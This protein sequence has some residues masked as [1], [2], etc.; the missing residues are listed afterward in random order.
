ME[1]DDDKA[2]EQFYLFLK[3]HGKRYYVSWPF[4]ED[5]ANL[6]DIYWLCYLILK[7]INKRLKEKGKLLLNYD[8]V[9]KDLEN[10][11]IIEEVPKKE[12]TLLVHYLP[13]Y[14][15]VTPSKKTTKIRILYDASPQGRKEFKSLNGC[16]YRGLVSLPKKDKETVIADN[17]DVDKKRFFLYFLRN[18]S[19]V[20]EN[21]P[22]KI[23]LSRTHKV[24]V[25]NLDFLQCESIKG[26]E[27]SDSTC[28]VTE[29]IYYIFSVRF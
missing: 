8:Q 16:L 19:V 1:K 2:L 20:I 26:L 10:Q 3:Y 12:E 15:V 4:K 13:L 17:L 23:K 18:L 25:S 29:Q 5:V 28:R 21:K 24:C 6:H 27:K 22:R 11:G 9:L 14:L 7:S